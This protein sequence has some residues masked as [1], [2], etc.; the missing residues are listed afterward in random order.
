MSNSKDIPRILISLHICISIHSINSLLYL[1]CL[2]KKG[3]F[4]KFHI[5]FA[6][7]EE[8]SKEGE[9]QGGGKM[10][11]KGQ[12]VVVICVL[13]RSWPEITANI[14]NA[15]FLLRTTNRQWS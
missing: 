5:D 9:Q 11:E 1:L 3:L 4:K 12:K 8:K 6:R 2:L 15:V 13:K 7:R 14:H 10:D